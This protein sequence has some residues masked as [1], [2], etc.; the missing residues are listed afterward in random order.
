MFDPAWKQP[1]LKTNCSKIKVPSKQPCLWY[2][3]G[4][5]GCYTCILYPNEG[6]NFCQPIGEGGL[7]HVS[8]IYFR[9]LFKKVSIHA[10]S[11][12]RKELG[13]KLGES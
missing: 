1:L 2:T 11:Y 13:A 9:F 10:N 4:P 5:R 7:L 3:P 6:G 8:F 12:P